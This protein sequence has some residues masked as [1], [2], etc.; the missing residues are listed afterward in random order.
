MERRLVCVNRRQEN[1]IKLKQEKASVTLQLGVD[2][3]GGGWKQA[4]W[5][6][7]QRGHNTF[8]RKK[9]IVLEGG[10]KLG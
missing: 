9:V 5:R 3:E 8:G 6:V 1:G 4:D 10:R 7:N 2:E